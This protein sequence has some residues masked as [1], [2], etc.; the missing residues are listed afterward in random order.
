MDLTRAVFA[1]TIKYQN[2]VELIQKLMDDV[3]IAA[4]A[5]D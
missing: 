1:V 4:I 2:R 3:K 5:I